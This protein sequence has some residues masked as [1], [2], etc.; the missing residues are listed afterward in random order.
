[1][2]GIELDLR[3]SQKGDRVMWPRIMRIQLSKSQLRNWMG[4]IIFLGHIWPCYILRVEESWDT[5]IGKC[6]NLRQ[7]ILL[8][9]SG[10]LRIPWLCL[11]YYTMLLEISQGCLFL[12]TNKRSLGCSYSDIFKNGEWNKNLWIEATG[13]WTTQGDWSVATFFFINSVICCRSWII[14]KI[15][16]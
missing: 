11:G 5:W 7:M 10:R 2:V 8:M 16:R 13:T 12:C 1:M 3:N 9:V 14:I 6:L 15:C 4:W